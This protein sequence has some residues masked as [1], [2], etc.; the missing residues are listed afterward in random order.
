D[1]ESEALFLLLLLAAGFLLLAAVDRPSSNLAVAAGL[2]A[3]LAALTRPTGLLLGA[4]LFAPLGDRRYPMRARWHLAGSALLGFL[5]AVSPW[6]LRNFLV[7]RELLPIN[8]A[9]GC[10]FYQG[11]S[12]WAVRFSEIRTP[13]EYDAWARSAFADMARDEA[14]LDRAG[15]T[16]RS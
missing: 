11:N 6:T 7:F 2:I 12:D 16:S 13:A 10:T 5:L 14:A 3:A 9:A 15:V 1:V 8:D 4:F